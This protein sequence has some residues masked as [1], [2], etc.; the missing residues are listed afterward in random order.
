MRRFGSDR[1]AGMMDRLGMEEDMPIESGLAARMIEQ[2]QTK[3]EAYYFDIR[4]NIVEYDDVIAKHREVIY[5]DRRDILEGIDVHER[6]TDMIAEEVDAAIRPL[7][8]E[9]LPENWNLEA[10]DAFFDHWNIPLPEDFFPENITQL[11]REPLI[12]SCVDWAL[13]SYEQRREKLDE[14]IENLGIKD[15][16]GDLIMQ[17]IERS[18]MLRV[19]DV[20]WMDHIDSIDVLRSGIGLR[21]IAQKDPLVEFKN[22]AYAAFDH[23]KAQIQH[24]V[25]ENAMLTQVSLQIPEPV[26]ATPPPTLMQTNTEAIAAATGQAK[27]EGGVATATRPAETKVGKE[28]K[29]TLTQ[30]KAIKRAV[31]GQPKSQSAT[32][33]RPIAPATNGA[34]TPSPAPST[35]TVA[36]KPIPSSKTV[37]RPLTVPKA[38]AVKSSTANGS[39]QIPKVGPNDPCPCGSKQKYK[40]CHGLAKK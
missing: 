3:V 17:G 8:G 28:P 39:T 21:S 31:T 22:E 19:V 25:A 1:V 15:T 32:S 4:K 27:S 24:F 36:T 40:F 38:P 20:L 26:S 29:R 37:S 12:K 6:V 33:S 13:D 14:Q 34:S 9:N 10:I 11:K 23:L 5:A 18:I 30:T 16:S 35:T 2:A 7:L